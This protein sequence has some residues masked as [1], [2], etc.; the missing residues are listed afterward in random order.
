MNSQFPQKAKEIMNMRFGCDSLIALATCTDNVPSVRTV[1]GFYENGAF[2]IIT[3]ALSDKMKQ[4]EKNPAVAVS[5]EWFAAHGTG[6]N[7]GWIRD[8]ANAE[9]ASKLRAAFAEWYD[10]G[11]IDESDPNTCILRVKLTDGTLSADG[12]KFHIDFT[13]A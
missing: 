2:Y 5:G 7:I 3:Y 13:C 1:D 12:E 6:E 8:E 10:N 11:H 9:I 4:I